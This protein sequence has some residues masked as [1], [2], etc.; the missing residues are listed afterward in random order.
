MSLPPQPL[1]SLEDIKQVEL[2]PERLVRLSAQV[3]AAA[4]AVQVEDGIPRGCVPM[5]CFTTGADDFREHVYAPLKK[6]IFAHITGDPEVQRLLRSLLYGI[7]CAV[8][9]YKE[10]TT[11]YLRQMYRH[12][13]LT[14]SGD[15]NS[16]KYLLVDAMHASD[17]DKKTP[18]LQK[19]CREFS[20]ASQL[21]DN[22]KTQKL[23]CSFLNTVLD[24]C[25][26][27]LRIDAS[28][29]NAY[30]RKTGDTYSCCL[31]N[32]LFDMLVDNQGGG[33]VA[34]RGNNNLEHSNTT[35]SAQQSLKMPN[36]FQNTRMTV[37]GDYITQ[38]GVTMIK[39]DVDLFSNRLSAAI[40]AINSLS[41]QLTPAAKKKAAKAICSELKSMLFH[42]DNGVLHLPRS[43]KNKLKTKLFKGE[44]TIENFLSNLTK[45]ATT[46]LQN[47]MES[48]DQMTIPKTFTLKTLLAMLQKWLEWRVVV[49]KQLSTAENLKTRFSQDLRFDR[50]HNR[51]LHRLNRE[52]RLQVP[53][54]RNMMMITSQKYTNFLFALTPYKDKDPGQAPSKLQRLSLPDVQPIKWDENCAH[55]VFDS[56]DAQDAQTAVAEESGATRQL[57]LKQHVSGMSISPLWDPFGAKFIFELTGKNLQPLC[58]N[59]DFYVLFDYTSAH[60][61][62]QVRMQDGVSDSASRDDIQKHVYHLL[63][64]SKSSTTC[65]FIQQ[66]PE[67]CTGR[68]S[69]TV[70]YNPE[71]L[72][73]WHKWYRF[74]AVPLFVSTHPH[75][76]IANKQQIETPFWCVIQPQPVSACLSSV[77]G[78]DFD[79][80]DKKING[81]KNFFELCIVLPCEHCADSSKRPLCSSA[82]LK[83]ST[84]SFE[85]ILPITK[86]VE[87][88]MTHGATKEYVYW[89]IK[90]GAKMPETAQATLVATYDYATQG[91]IRS[92]LLTVTNKA[93]AQ[94]INLVSSSEDE[95]DTT[96]KPVGEAQR[97]QSA[98]NDTT[99]EDEDDTTGEPVGEAQRRQSAKNGTSRKVRFAVYNEQNGTQ[100]KKPKI[101]E[102][103]QQQVEH[104]LATD[105]DKDEG[106][107][108]P[109][110]KLKVTDQVTD[111]VTDV[112]P[113]GFNF[114]CFQQGNEDQRD[115]VIAPADNGP[116]EGDQFVYDH[117]VIQNKVKDGTA[118]VNPK[119][120]QVLKTCDGKIVHFVEETASGYWRVKLPAGKTCPLLKEALHPVTNTKA[121]RPLCQRILANY[122]FYTTDLQQ[123]ICK[124]QDVFSFCKA[125]A[126]DYPHLSAAMTQYVQSVLVFNAD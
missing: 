57:V 64:A 60:P 12:Q 69:V 115:E 66:Q 90:K 118:V 46:P 49:C 111:Q 113:V 68:F 8:K 77:H 110:K 94:A 39:T 100:V 101:A 61:P 97:R 125:Y 79:D 73:H 116:L 104:V 81:S 84:E 28:S 40:T 107:K 19:I 23:I 41:Q 65:E 45:Y 54:E 25:H 35:A 24:V 71:Q 124:S 83:L 87:P 108:Q 112:E 58:R 75:S 109:L 122:G 11:E 17:S 95:D 80:D 50:E 6:A 98:E 117:N 96:G 56:Q 51:V 55:L 31:L 89:E 29:T 92:N 30:F 120:L 32:M 74:F 99:S 34:G 37:N 3:Q 22:C 76:I 38:A 85:T 63:Q 15:T 42:N 9:A 105:S 7:Y 13:S 70:R 121:L 93:S 102:S 33:S 78:I 47:K 48:W 88:D 86:A 52:R 18:P 123:A 44:S 10:Y 20:T 82:Q 126:I 36:D 16:D 91:P 26:C 43:D 62:L 1:V 21:K 27:E 119:T 4:D 59:D 53:N 72:D 14:D 106:A 67:S 114:A 5:S 103:Q 2:S